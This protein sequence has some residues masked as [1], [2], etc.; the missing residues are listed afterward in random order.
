MTEFIRYLVALLTWFAAEPQA[1]DLERPRCAACV[2]AAH[3][4][5]T[6]E[7]PDAEQNKDAPAAVVEIE[8]ARKTEARRLE[9]TDGSGSRLL[10]NEAQSLAPGCADGQCLAVPTVRPRLFRKR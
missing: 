2:L 6:K 5:Q 3:A 4:S 10:L 1:V 9:P 8:P 7:K